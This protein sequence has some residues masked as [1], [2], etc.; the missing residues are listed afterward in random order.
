MADLLR[1][2]AAVAAT[3]PAARKRLGAL[4]ADAASYPNGRVS[5]DITDI[6]LRAVM[7]ALL[8]GGSSVPR[9]GDGINTNDKPYL[10]TF[11]YQASPHSG[12]DRRLSN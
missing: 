3:A 11:P 1:L 4:A 10:E 5:D 9:L 8:P 6:T 7:G 2:N 12:R